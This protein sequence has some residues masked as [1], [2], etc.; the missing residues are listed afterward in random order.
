MV[1]SHVYYCLAD[2]RLAARYN[3]NLAAPATLN[4]SP[5]SKT[6]AIG[7]KRH[8]PISSPVLSDGNPPGTGK[9]SPVASTST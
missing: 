9:T 7:T 8:F 3:S 2:L 5:N 1:G 4:M 6:S